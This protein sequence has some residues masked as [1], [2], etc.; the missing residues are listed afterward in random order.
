M[1]QLSRK[2][3][4]VTNENNNYDYEKTST[5]SVHVIPT[6]SNEKSTNQQ[7]RNISFE[8]D[9]KDDVGSQDVSLI[10]FIKL[11]FT[12]LLN[13]ENHQKLMNSHI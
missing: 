4:I 9:Q 7:T 8:D 5:R 6:I 1:S 2:V 10:M 11:F 3:S 13:Y 12:I